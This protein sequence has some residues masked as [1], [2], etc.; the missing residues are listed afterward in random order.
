MTAT[1]Y[2]E[3]TRLDLVERIHGHDVADPYRWLEDGLAPETQVWLAAQDA[4]CRPY[5]DSLPGR[6]RWSK[7][8][9]ELMVGFL[10]KPYA[11]GNRLFF[12][13]RLPD[14]QHAVLFVEEGGEAR[15]LV[16][17]NAMSAEA[18]VTLDGWQPS[19]EGDLLAYQISEG[20]D[21]EANLYVLDVST[22]EV[23]D[24]PIDRV[25]YSNVAW[26]PGGREFY[27]TR[28]LPPAAVPEGEAQFHR[29]VYR[30]TLG[31]NPDND[32]EVFGAGRDKT[33]YYG[34]DVS[35]DGR[36]LV[37][38]AHLGTAPR[39][40]VYLADLARDGVLRP[41]QEGEDVDTGAHVADDGRLYL[42]TNRGAPRRRL[43]VADPERP[44]PDRWRD[45][46]AESDGVLTDFT[47]TDSSVVAVHERH[48]VQ[49][50]AVHR[51]ETGEKAADVELPGLGVVMVGSRQD[52]GDDVWIG[53]SD[54]VCPFAVFELDV[55]TGGIREWRPQPSVPEISGISVRQVEYDSKDGT[56]VR[57][58]VLAREDVELDS[59]RPTILYGYGGFNISLTPVYDVDALAWVEA[60]GV[61]AVANLRGGSE[62]GEEWHRAGMRADKQNV[63]D[64]F[65]AA[66][67]WLVSAGYTSP[68]RLAVMGGSNGGLLV[69]AALTQR[70][71]LFRAVVCSAPL[72]DMV[73]YELFGLGESWN[74]EYGTARDPEEFE[75]L[76]SYSPYHRV[77]DGVAYPAVLFTS[78]DSD[79]RTDPLH[80]RK[81]CAALQWATSSSHPVLFRRESD[82]GHSVRSVDRSI[83][84]MTDMLV[85]LADQLGLDHA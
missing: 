17:V 38:M 28:R 73:R 18:L 52:G 39:N 68:G 55:R 80:P 6:E 53:Y 81:M 56:R 76:Y 29:R 35:R 64:D 26:L 14:E 2:P 23:V 75:W 44:G 9:R 24:G 45:L 34:V 70:P 12:M 13:R 84:L 67:E 74:D 22:G 78:F 32:V 36:W 83:H 85:F 65:I 15:P 27:F 31:D 79:T 58:F 40:D 54:Y 50:V 47:V 19:V 49:R 60:G 41:V 7:R 21:E 77:Q 48:A 42:L 20:G 37:V 51:R 66:A 16:D 61:Y 71:D 25:R 8:L 33:T 82:V 10:G 11:V 5:L 62:E 59:D 3:T 30:H 72:L 63:F 1:R 4:L 69:G 46:I 57:M 43:M